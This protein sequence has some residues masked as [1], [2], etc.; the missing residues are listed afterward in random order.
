LKWLAYTSEKAILVVSN[1]GFINWSWSS[2]AAMRAGAYFKTKTQVISLP[3]NS[4]A[5]NTSIHNDRKGSPV[6]G[7]VWF[8]NA[9]ASMSLREM[10]SS[11]EQ[12]GTIFTL[13]ILPSIS[14]VWM[15]WSKSPEK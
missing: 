15:P 5:A 4:I 11:S 14:D 2:K 12:Y 3:E 7:K 10:K 1:D 8:Q 6:A 9:E 13:L